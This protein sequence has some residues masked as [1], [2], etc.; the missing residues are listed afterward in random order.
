MPEC[1]KVRLFDYT[2]NIILTNSMVPEMNRTSAEMTLSIP[3]TAKN[4]GAM[5]IHQADQTGVSRCS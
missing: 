4:Q 5:V 3:K 1:I 2:K